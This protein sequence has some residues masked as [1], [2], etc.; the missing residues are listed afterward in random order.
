MPDGGHY[1]WNTVLS[2]GRGGQAV[3]ARYESPQPN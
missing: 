2:N 3:V 1:S